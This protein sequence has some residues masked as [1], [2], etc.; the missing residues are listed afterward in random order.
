MIRLRKLYTFP[1]VTKT[2][3]FE[4][5]LNFILG[6]R[7]ESSN[8]TNGV[9]KSMCIEFINFCLLRKESGSRVLKIPKTTLPPE[10][11][12]LLDIEINSR[13]VTIIRTTKKPNQIGRAH[14]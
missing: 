7:T 10:T 6:E 3:V 14:V 2:V 11:Q 12:I 13:P 9:G 1:E 5:G 8:K 4:D